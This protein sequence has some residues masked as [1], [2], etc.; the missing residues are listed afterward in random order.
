MSASE[1][2]AREL[3]ELKREIQELKARLNEESSQRALADQSLSTRIQALSAK[4]T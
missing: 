4:P 2:I 3:E 1:M